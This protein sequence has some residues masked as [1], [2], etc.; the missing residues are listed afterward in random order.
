MLAS[1]TTLP[2]V[3]QNV[4][5]FTVFVVDDDPAVRDMLWEMLRLRGIDAEVFVSG[6]DFLRYFR[7]GRPGVL[8][9][10]IHMPG[11]S[12]HEV[13]ARLRERGSELP[14]IVVTG[15]GD[16]PLAV[17]AMKAGAFDVIEK[18]FRAGPLVALIDKARAEVEAHVGE[19]ASREEAARRVAKLTNREREVLSG[20]VDGLQTKHIAEQLNVSARTV[21]A[22]RANII[23]KLEVKNAAGAVRLA[24]EAGVEARVGCCRSH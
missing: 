7:P 2:D 8:L 9:L 19:T 20:L 18:P 5:N 6:D 4:R 24:I 23:R 17:E 11:L 21:D 14:V 3:A 22:H 12:G 10:D 1:K 16:V 15:R 13:M